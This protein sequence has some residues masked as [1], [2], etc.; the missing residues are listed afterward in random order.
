MKIIPS[1]WPAAI[2]LIAIMTFTAAQAS[3]MARNHPS[4][5]TK[6]NPCAQIACAKNAATPPGTYPH[7]TTNAGDGDL[8]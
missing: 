5:P 6:P 7:P 2:T 3:M 8:K 1:V 4:R